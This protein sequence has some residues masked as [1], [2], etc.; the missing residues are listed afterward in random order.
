VTRRIRSRPWRLLVGLLIVGS[1]AAGCNR[2]TGRLSPDDTIGYIVPGPQA[3]AAFRV[4]PARRM[5]ELPAVRVA[6]VVRDAAERE[7]VARSQAPECNRYFGDSALVLVL[8]VPPCGPD[9][10]QVRTDGRWL[11]AFDAEGRPLGT[12]DWYLNDAATVV[13]FMRLKSH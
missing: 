13:P 10:V 8:F 2:T 9:A 12:I 3:A 11:A 4:S 5:P 1:A 6:Q 7:A